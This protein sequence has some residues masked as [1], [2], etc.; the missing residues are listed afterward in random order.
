MSNKRLIRP[1]QRQIAKSLGVSPATVSLAL[2]N[3]PLVAEKTRL[4]VQEA[5]RETGYVRNVA[6][7]S[8]RTGRSSLVGVSIHNIAHA[9]Y[10]EILSAI[11]RTLAK[12]GI[13]VLFNNHDDCPEN[14]TGFVGVLAT[15]GVDGLIVVPPPFAQPA[16]FE[17][18][19]SQ[20]AAIVYLSRHAE[21]DTKA[22]WS[23]TASG[24]AARL[25]TAHLIEL[26][27]SEIVLVGGVPGTSVS[28]ERVA[29]YHH[30]LKEADL[31][32]INQNW[33]QARPR[34]E[35]GIAA[36]RSV[37]DRN[38]R[39]TGLVCFNDLVGYSAM[40]VARE[41]GLVPGDD[42]SIVALGSSAAS[43][44]IHPGLT[45]VQHDPAELGRSAAL[46]LIERLDLPEAVPKHTQLPCK[47]VLGESSSK[48]VA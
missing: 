7:A 27:H 38:N 23:V 34:V 6:A 46:A 37:L 14:L 3:S 13:V 24:D 36:V 1:T 31:P 41:M 28:D 39:P 45:T 26:G 32:V 12:A 17:P 44:Q 25:A 30:A 11:E 48:K 2:R 10:G 15:Y 43:A 22:D 33:V 18:I 8:L 40:N 29:G 9:R 47:L 19:T 42:I 5:M 4:R 35:D 16:I 20:G 21:G